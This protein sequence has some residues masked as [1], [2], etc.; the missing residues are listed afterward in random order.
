MCIQSYS[1]IL[2]VQTTFLF[3]NFLGRKESILIRNSNI[4]TKLLSVTWIYS[5]RK[6]NLLKDQKNAFL[7]RS[8]VETWKTSKQLTKQITNLIKLSQSNSLN[9]H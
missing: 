6:N 3:W 7:Q 9:D 5:F 2:E 4:M 1:R 8:Q